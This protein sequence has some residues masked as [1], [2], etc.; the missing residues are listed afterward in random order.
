MAAS[1]KARGA[2]SKRISRSVETLEIYASGSLKDNIRV[3]YSA[4][5]LK[6]IE[7]LIE[8][9]YD[10]SSHLVTDGSDNVELVVGRVRY[11]GFDRIS[12]YAGLSKQEKRRLKKAAELRKILR[13]CPAWHSEHDHVSNLRTN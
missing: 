11:A 1:N 13:Y 12:W 2:G 7:F 3:E 8:R 5:G 9:G 10:V 4:S 6:T